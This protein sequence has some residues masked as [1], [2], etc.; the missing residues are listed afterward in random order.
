MDL[1][2]EWSGSSSMSAIMVMRDEDNKKN[3]CMCVR[4]NECCSGDDEWNKEEGK[5]KETISIIT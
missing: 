2:S 4:L 3:E 5:R 1:K